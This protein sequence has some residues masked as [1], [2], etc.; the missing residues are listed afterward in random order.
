MTYNVVTCAEVHCPG[1]QMY[2]VCGDS[3]ARSCDDLREAWEDRLDAS[4]EARCHPQCVEGC[5]CP[6]GQALDTHGECVP[7]ASCP[8]RHAGLEF[9][10]QYKEVRPG[11]K[12]QELWLVEAVILSIGHRERTQHYLFTSI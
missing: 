1:G 6:V 11:S 3:C 7:Q 12:Q 4:Q 9:P 2:Q 5:N 10:P 8:C